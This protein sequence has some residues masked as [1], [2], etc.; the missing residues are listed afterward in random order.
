MELHSPAEKNI[1]RVFLFLQGHPSFFARNVADRL[2]KDGNEV[3]RINF[4][5]GDAILWWGRKAFNYRLPFSHW[6]GY[7][8]EFVD[9]HGVTDIVYYA[10]RKPYHQIA[11]KVAND[12]GIP[13]Y[14]YEFGYLRP[15]W[16]TLERG[17]MSGFSHFPTDPHAIRAV[18]SRC[19]EPDLKQ[20]YPYTKPREIVFEVSYNL[21]SYFL[22]FLYPFYK[23]DR[24]YNP[25]VEYI[26]G[27]PGLFLEKRRSVAA[28][29]LVTKLG[30]EKR[31]FYVFSLQ[32]Q[33][34]YQLRSNSPFPHQKKAIESTLVSFARN[35]GTRTNL[36]LKAHP[37]DNGFEHWGRFIRK[38][39]KE[40]GVSDRVHYVI[41]GNLTFMLKHA[42]GCIMINSTVG[43]HSVRSGCPVK[44]LGHAI[45]DIKGLTHQGTIDSFWT[46][47]QSPDPEF[48]K[49][50]VKA[51]AGTIQV[52]GNFF[53]AKGNKAGVP[54]FARN[55][56]E[57]RVNG[58]GAFVEVPPRL[59]TLRAFERPLYSQLPVAI[60]VDSTA[61]DIRSINDIKADPVLDF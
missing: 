46:Q 49:D 9:K 14:A 15:D 24:Y 41:G 50:F 1:K 60:E 42:K 29:R 3:L 45:F 59:M 51:L 12:C 32:L 19:D 27:I 57:R 52:K 22:W 38:K 44:V 5:L 55:L 36:I 18:A 39:A 8:R 7:L 21:L 31:P 17:G 25:L 26:S 2:E 11:A 34:D 33:S 6:E 4:C 53:T 61:E 43:L 28:R 16:I 40:L 23:A 20:K 47:P 48:V 13:T 37:L 30:R 35:T 54:A 10:D 56:V 58:L